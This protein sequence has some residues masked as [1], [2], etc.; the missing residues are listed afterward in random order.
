MALYGVGLD[1]TVERLNIE[2]KL[3]MSRKGGASLKVLKDIFQKLDK[4]GNNKLELDEFKA[5]LNKFGFFPK[6]VDLQAIHKY[7]DLD[8]DGYVNFE[9]FLQGLR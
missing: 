7:Y 6:F 4:N 5:A 3:A 8:G 2:F 9:E 1:T